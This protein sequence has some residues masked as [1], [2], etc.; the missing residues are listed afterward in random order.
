MYNLPYF[1]GLIS[2]SQLQLAR[3]RSI[4]IEITTFCLFIMENIK[5]HTYESFKIQ[6]QFLQNIHF[7]EAKSETTFR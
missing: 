4:I 6:E 5:N 7:I 3:K 2:N 1:D